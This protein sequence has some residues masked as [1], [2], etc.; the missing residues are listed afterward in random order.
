MEPPRPSRF[1]RCQ[2]LRTIDSID[3]KALAKALREYRLIWQ[4]AGNRRSE[5]LIYPSGM[6]FRFVSVMFCRWFGEATVAMF[7]PT[8]QAFIG[9][10]CAEWHDVMPED[11]KEAALFMVRCMRR[12]QKLERICQ[13]I[14]DYLDPAPSPQGSPQASDFWDK[15]INVE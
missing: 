2:Y 12:L 4:E 7:R 13:Q 14:T 15:T 10:V 6:V 9:F 11:E 3:K 8:L 5:G 1:P